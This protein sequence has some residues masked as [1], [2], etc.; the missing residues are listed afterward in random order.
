MAEKFYLASQSAGFISFK[1]AIA[2]TS[3]YSGAADH[4]LTVYE[5]LVNI[6]GNGRGY[7]IA[8]E[9]V[10]IV[11][12]LSP[13]NYVLY[14]SAPT[15]SD[16]AG[17]AIIQQPVSVGTYIGAGDTIWDGDD[18]GRRVIC[19]FRVILDE[20]DSYNHIDPT[21][22]RTVI[23]QGVLDATQVL[24]DY[25]VLGF[26]DNDFI[27]RGQNV[28]K[29]AAL[30]YPTTVQNMDLVYYKTTFFDPALA[31]DAD[32]EQ[33]AVIGIVDVSRD[34]VFGNNI[35]IT[36]GVVDTTGSGG[37][38][39]LSTD[40]E[41]YA[42]GTYLYLSDTTAGKIERDFIKWIANTTHVADIY[43]VTNDRIWRAIN[44]GDTHGSTK[45][46]TWDNPSV[47]YKTGDAFVD[48]TN[49]VADNGG[50]GGS[51]IDWGYHADYEGV[52]EGDM[53]VRIGISLGSGKFL[54][55]LAT[56]AGNIDD[57]NDFALAHPDIIT[58]MQ[59]AG[60]WTYNQSQGVTD[61]EYRGQY[62]DENAVFNA[63][64]SWSDNEISLIYMKTDGTY[65][66][67]LNEAVDTILER[68]IGVSHRTNGS[69][70]TGYV[71]SSGYVHYDT[72]LIED[73]AGTAPTTVNP[74]DILYLSKYNEGQFANV[75]QTTDNTR[76]GMVIA[77]GDSVTGTIL[78]S[79]VGGSAA[80]LDDHDEG[81]FS[82][83]NIQ[84]EM[85]KAGIYVRGNTD[86]TFTYRGQM[87]D[88]DPSYSGVSDYDLVYH[89][90]DGDYK[91]AQNLNSTPLT[92]DV[93]GIAYDVSD[94][95]YGGVL[96]GGFVTYDT[97]DATKIWDDVT[98]AA[99]STVTV[100]E[101]LYL[102]K[103]SAGAISNTKDTADNV[104]VGYVIAKGAV[105][106]GYIFLRIGQNL[107]LENFAVDENATFEGTVADYEF[108]YRKS[109][110]TYTKAK[111]DFDDNPAS[112]V[113]GIAFGITSTAGVMISHGLV[114]YDTTSI[115]GT[116]AVVGD[117]AYLSYTTSG[118][119]TT[120]KRN[121]NNIEVATVVTI[122]TVAA[123]GTILINILGD[124]YVDTAIDQFAHFNSNVD[125]YDVVYVYD[126]SGLEYDR[127]IVDNTAKEYFIGVCTEGP[128]VG[129]N[130]IVQSQGYV[131][132]G[133]DTGTGADS[134]GTLGYVVTNTSLAIGD[135]VYLSLEASYP[136]KVT[137]LPSGVEVGRYIGLIGSNYYMVITASTGGEDGPVMASQEDMQYSG[138]LES[139]SFLRMHYDTFSQPGTVT[140]DASFNDSV[141]NGIATEYI[142]KQIISETDD[143]WGIQAWA[144][145]DEILAD[146][147]IW[148][149]IEAGTSSG[150]E[151][152]WTDKVSTSSLEAHYTMDDVTGTT[153]VDETSNSYDG[154]ASSELIQ[155]NIGHVGKS[156]FL[157]GT[158]EINTGT[159]FPTALGAAVTNFSVSLAFQ[160]NVTS[161][162]DGLFD[163][164]PY[165]GTAGDFYLALVSGNLTFGLT[166]FSD[167]HAFTDISDKFH[168]LVATYDGS[169]PTAKMY[170]DGVEVTSETI[171]VPA[172]LDLSNSTVNQMII[173][174]YKNTSSALNGHVDQVRVYSVTLSPYEIRNLHREISN[175][176]E[177]DV[178]IE[179]A[180]G[181][182]WEA[183]RPTTDYRFQVHA[184]YVE[185]PRMVVEYSIDE[186]PSTWIKIPKY[187]EPVLV[188]GGFVDLHLR[189]TWGATGTINSFG[190]M[191]GYDNKVIASIKKMFEIY[192]D[193]GS[194]GSPNDIITIPNNGSY[195]KDGVSL[196]LTSDTNGR[197][198]I[199]TDFEENDHYSVKMLYGLGVSESLIFEE[200]YGAVDNSLENN[201]LILAQHQAVTGY[202]TAKE[203]N[204]V[205]AD[206]LDIDDHFVTGDNGSG[207]TL[208]LLPVA[209]VVE[210]TFIFVNIG[211]SGTFTLDPDSSETINGSA[212]SLALTTQWDVAVLYA[213]LTGWI[214]IV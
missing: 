108:V 109:D 202:H 191:Y 103:D 183:R 7:Y 206:T 24:K 58:A 117:K 73:G 174:S 15:G 149:C 204:Y 99:A 66:K 151:P 97:Q 170:L 14:A 47:Y 153:V 31:D 187:D 77:T 52:F 53:K 16:T 21:S 49:G 25:G 80:A 188:T 193:S 62:F 84:N 146:S 121:T 168:S 144:L 2:D 28:I 211:A 155:V 181:V 214:R 205:S 163:I 128:T 101:K 125:A 19:T 132:M 176:L 71:L 22:V 18:T 12:S 34:G 100:G 154:T 72:T 148:E 39:D 45:P 35:V 156:M 94:T 79:F 152:S 200:Y 70:K 9:E 209:S 69:G 56:G 6:G 111:L 185:E 164:G 147:W 137:N 55:G 32:K 106:T 213:A 119:L 189:F 199:G 67:A 110:S 138:L 120:T 98:Q 57:H 83:D 48:G 167:V 42:E 5:G 201:Q 23:S 141:Y 33:E 63:A 165:V 123:G 150:S 208:T 46:T 20:T 184:E 89:A 95:D 65:G 82:H 192:T 135:K 169:G 86:H 203:T 107:S 37:Q 131:D 29:D 17:K 161:G 54:L 85:M 133:T 171:S 74:G 178:V 142:Q 88:E 4:R 76:V 177:E 194:G 43:M 130:G 159:T 36:S 212:S 175:S 10:I 44:G 96:S 30:D 81:A 210:R 40:A 122:G 127:A 143:T 64:E 124:R 140:G 3:T 68:A 172:S 87:F 180:G 60:L 50:S 102:S 93:V 104:E 75:P 182:V 92:A 8:E 173:G 160:A 115:E 118:L 166:G 59:K 134:T 112:A 51:G 157:P 13:G 90:S 145:E 1:Q 158:G 129:D 41:L 196:Q 198:F 116:T 26:D 78:I 139:S 190:V 136:G 207:L 195:T 186:S 179:D 27:Y 38:N 114:A 91:Q 197:L 162:D 105:G 11:P 113:V 126:N 61:F